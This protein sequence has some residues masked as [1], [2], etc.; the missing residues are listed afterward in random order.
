VIPNILSERAPAASDMGRFETR[1]VLFIGRLSRQ[2]G[3]DLFVKAVGKA[4]QTSRLDAEIVGSGED[5]FEA[6]DYRPRRL[7]AVPWE[8]R[9][10][11]FRGASLVVVPSR[12]EPFGMVILEAMHHRVP[13]IY[14]ERSGAAEVLQS[15]I[16]VDPENSEEV[17]RRIVELLGDLGAWEA[18]V[19]AQAEEI[20]SYPDRNYEDQII[21]VW[22]GASAVWETAEPSPP[23]ETAS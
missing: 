15:G 6:A 14:P 1:R 10:D 8:K 11:A 19:R 2:K 16:K 21:A 4:R 3:V 5:D 22:R 7:G 23:R 20:D 17:S 12:F 13:V 9:G 18:I